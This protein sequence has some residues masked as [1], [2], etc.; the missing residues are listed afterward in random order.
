MA[1]F[2]AL[3]ASA[4]IH[5]GVSAVSSPQ[6]AGT[7]FM[8]ILTA[9][10]AD[11]STNVTYQS[12]VSLTATGNA[13]AEI[14]SP[15]NAS[16][17]INGVWIGA[18]R[19]DKP[20]A[21]VQITVSDGA[22][23]QVTGNA[24]NVMPG[25]LDHFAFNLIPSPQHAGTP[26]SATITAEDAGN[27][28]F[29]NFTGSVNLSALTGQPNVIF[30]ANFEDGLD[31]FTINNTIGQSNGSGNGL[32]HL[33][34]GQATNGGHSAYHSLY[35]GRNETLF[36]GGNY[37]TGTI[38]EG[39]VTSPLIDLTGQSAP[40][41]LSFNYFLDSDYYFYGYDYA[42]IEISQNG[43]SFSN[44]TGF[45]Y[46]SFGWQPYSLD[47][48]GFASS[49]IQIRFHF[50]SKLQYAQHEGWYIDDVSV[51]NGGNPD[52]LLLNPVASA[53]FTNGTWSGFVSVLD[54]FTNVVLNATDG[55]GHSGASQGFAV[56]GTADVGASIFVSPDV[57][58]AGSSLLYVVL[59]TNGGPNRASFVTLNDQLAP[60]VAF[61]SAEV[62]QGTWA[63]NPGSN[64]ISFSL[65]GLDP[66]DLAIAVLTVAPS[67]KM[68]LTNS[69]IASTSSA[70]TNQSNN[71][72]SALAVVNGEGILSVYGGDFLPFSHDGSPFVPSSQDYTVQ[73]IGTAP[74][75]WSAG[76]AF[77][78][79]TI[80]P[81]SGTLAPFTATNVTVSVNAAAS[82]LPFG[83]YSNTLVFSNLTDG[84]GTTT[85][86]AQLTSHMS[87]VAV[88]ASQPVRTADARWFGMNTAIWDNLLNTPL[89]A[90]ILTNMGTRA[91]RYPG[92]SLSDEYHWL[93]NQVINGGYS[94]PSA[95]L[96]NFIQVA[97][98]INAITMITLNYGSGSSNEAAAWV[99]YVNAATGGT[100]PLGTDAA[101]FN[102]QT[103]GYWASL[104]A[105]AKLGSDD[106]RNFLRISRQAP[107]GFKYWEIGNELYGS[108]ETDTNSQPHDPYT[109]AL[110]AGGYI[111]LMKAVDP[112]I[113][114]GVVVTPGEDSFSDYND[115][116]AYN[117]R[118]G[119]YHYGWTPILLATLSSLGITPDF[120]I[121]H[122]YPQNAG[123]E[124]DAALLASSPGWT[125]D[126]ADLRQQVT[127]YMGAAV[128]T[129]VELL[130]TENNSVS[131]TPGKQSVSLVNGLYRADSMA[132]LMQTEF[133]AFFWWDLR[134][135][136][137]IDG[138]LSPSLYG[139]RQYGDYGIINGNSTPYPTYYLGELMK[140]FIQPGDTV[141]GSTNDF[142]LL[143]TYAAR[144]L[145]GGLT[146]LAINKDPSNTI[147]APV[148]LAGFAPDFYGTAYTYGI[149]QDLSFETRQGS[150]E[151]AQ[152]GFSG[153]GSNFNYAFPPYSATVLALAPKPPQLSARLSP[154]TQDQFALQLL[155]QNGVPYLIQ[156][157][158]DLIN[159]T[160]ISTNTPSSGPVNLTN[161]FIPSSPTQFFR[162]LWQP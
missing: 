160:T 8:L 158:P 44:L 15:T 10:N 103:A 108:W 36:G 1:A 116:P 21:N 57:V 63:F 98:N 145:D 150:G 120:L 139:W 134:N 72:A 95:S 75:D 110:R 154:Q 86:G 90:V 162:A 126:A 147:T 31:G 33:S 125:A 81:A 64:A 121:H 60:N 153:A 135:E 7:P 114:I 155:G 43:G 143:S 39:A 13:G 5:L 93:S 161:S 67:I 94:S 54:A 20:D 97:T 102:W 11:G 55:S 96:P 128:G 50:Y 40:V 157:S 9:L 91:L 51:S 111:A 141:L 70:D 77:N 29:T 82:N 101:G 119:H 62:S 69:V 58:Q 129:N 142:P 52:S 148:L 59:V 85:F 83:V 133:N 159:W 18:V 84:N 68:L 61:S 35:Y 106:G 152:S 79:V 132:Q 22:G 32:W 46:P 107:L 104:R 56:Q 23:H 144:Q 122:R 37:N 14:I 146:I 124:N 34:T 45:F 38:N 17:W 140:Y 26:F 41:T 25:P 71:A 137:E 92:G 149:P 30:S 19:V 87:H 156:S 6:S 131:S 48:S 74:L 4:Q 113:K 130:C 47:L 76:A 49:Q 138:N 99:A 53:P 88:N 12:P 136:Q 65:G 2:A 24:F 115:A 3:N 27:N 123:G 109:Y 42:W 118:E 16:A 78:W 151:I 100:Q 112:T 105:A 66:G 117:S 28:P 73:N 127:D 89:T 80:S